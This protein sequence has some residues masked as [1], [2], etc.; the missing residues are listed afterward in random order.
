MDKRKFLTYTKAIAAI[1]KCEKRSTY[2]IPS[3]KGKYGTTGA[4]GKL[5]CTYNYMKRKLRSD[6]ILVDTLKTGEEE[7]DDDI[8]PNNAAGEINFY[9]LE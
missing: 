4:K 1:F 7:E 5:Y 8:A 2:Y 6:N 9:F 3:I